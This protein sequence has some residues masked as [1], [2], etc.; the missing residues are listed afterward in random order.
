MDR[1]FFF[2]DKFKV[3]AL[4]Q[5]PFG[6][7]VCRLASFL[8]LMLNICKELFVVASLSGKLV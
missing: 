4:L 8:A 5:I 1:G 6:L 7:G 2:F 3:M